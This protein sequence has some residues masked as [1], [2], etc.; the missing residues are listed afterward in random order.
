MAK[1]PYK[2]RG[3]HIFMSNILHNRWFSFVFRL[4]K[5][6]KEKARLLE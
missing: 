2:N 1:V 6:D 3:N 5:A 4:Y